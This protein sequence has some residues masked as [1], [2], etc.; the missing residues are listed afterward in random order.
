MKK[1]T[2]HIYIY[3]YMEM[4]MA[5]RAQILDE[6]VCISHSINI[7]GKERIKLFLLKLQINKRVGWGL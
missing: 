4:D 6:A 7:L 3:I 1:T 2:T 5:T